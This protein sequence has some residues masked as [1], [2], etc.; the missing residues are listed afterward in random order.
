M[1]WPQNADLEQMVVYAAPY[2]G[3][4]AIVKDPTQFVKVSAQNKP[5]IRIFTSAGRLLSKIQV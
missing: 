3:P 4:I 2:G 1:D 5:M